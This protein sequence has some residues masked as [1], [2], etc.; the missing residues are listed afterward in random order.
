MFESKVKIDKDLL[1]RAEEYAKRK[2]YPT[3]EEFISHLVEKELKQA[4]DDTPESQED[5]K[6]KLQG[7]GYIS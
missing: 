2:G 6:K 3:V 5:L 4:E 7:L 1:K